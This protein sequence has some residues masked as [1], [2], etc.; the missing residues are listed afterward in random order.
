M[1]VTVKYKTNKRRWEPRM[2]FETDLDDAGNIIFDYSG[3]LGSDTVDTAT[4]TTNDV[5]AGTPS[6][7][8]NTVTTALSGFTEGS[9]IKLEMKITTA[10][11]QTLTNLVRFRAIDYYNKY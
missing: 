6:I 4:A 1:T 3:E 9:D 8:S 10:G 2:L 5:T 7:S 11:G